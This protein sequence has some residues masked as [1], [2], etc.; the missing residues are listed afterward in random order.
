MEATA[1]FT[2]ILLA[3]GV[4][5]WADA[6]SP[7]LRIVLQALCAIVLAVPSAIYIIKWMEKNK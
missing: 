6:Y 3:A 5:M 1:I 4:F 7:A 2:L